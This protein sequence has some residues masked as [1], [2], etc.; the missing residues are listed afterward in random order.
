MDTSSGFLAGIPHTGGSWGKQKVPGSR[1]G[2]T[3]GH[4]WSRTSF[5]SWLSS[6]RQEGEKHPQ[7]PSTPIL[8][9]TGVLTW[10]DGLREGREKNRT[11]SA[12]TA[13]DSF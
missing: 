2:I 6:G 8:P 9:V 3:S 5:S 13:G 1:S 11:P 12:R 4:L 10:E 7:I